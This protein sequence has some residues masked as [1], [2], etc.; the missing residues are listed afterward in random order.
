MP[1]SHKSLIKRVAISTDEK[2]GI[3]ISKDSSAFLWDIEQNKK[4]LEFSAS[5]Y[6]ITGLCMAANG[7]YVVLSSS[8]GMV[9][10]WDL[11]KKKKVATLESH[12]GEV[13]DV[14]C[15]PDANV[16]FSAGSDGTIRIWE[17]NFIWPLIVEQNYLKVVPE[18]KK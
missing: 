10:I 4:I 17:N 16:I 11:Q 12:K 2:L 7:K 1:E 9:S 15:T 6:E 3:S 18:L 13:N 14:S 8:D 5:K